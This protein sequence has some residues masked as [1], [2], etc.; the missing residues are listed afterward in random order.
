MQDL[1]ESKDKDKLEQRAL[2]LINLLSARS[3]INLQNFGIHGSIALGMHSSKSDIDFVVYGA[4]NFRKLEST[5]NCLVESGT[6]SYKFSN[7]LDVARRF[8]GKYL[9]KTFM[10]NAVRKP[11][12]INAEYGAFR[13][14]PITPVKI[15][16]KIEDDSEAMFRPAIYKVEDCSPSDAKSAVVH[17]RSPDVVVSM[18]GC[19]RNVARKGDAIKVS[20]TLERIERLKTGEVSYQVVVGTGTSEDEHIW[21]F[22]A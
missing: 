22:Q 4:Q 15:T 18:I 20:G 14:T 12:E 7:R 10:Y 19:Y 2:D 16:C 9:D 17:D 5:T 13:F 3:G 11:E 1:L 21:P 6:L 8:K